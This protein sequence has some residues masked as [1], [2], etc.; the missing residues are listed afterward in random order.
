VVV[1]VVVVVDAVDEVVVDDV[2]V[3]VVDAVVVVAG[4]VL[5]V[6]DGAVIGGASPRGVTQPA[7]KTRSATALTTRP[8]RSTVPPGASP[9]IKGT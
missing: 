2:D 8:V 5:V 4:A 1:A 6:V 7:V 3:V 9:L